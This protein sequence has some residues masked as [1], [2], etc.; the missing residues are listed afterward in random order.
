MIF[1][2]LHKIL[3]SLHKKNYIIEFYS[4]NAFSIALSFYH[5][6]SPYNGLCYISKEAERFS[7]D[8]QYHKHNK[9]VKKQLEN[10][11]KMVYTLYKLNQLDLVKKM[12]DNYKI[13]T[14]AG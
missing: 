6:N 14:L 5:K 3:N 1:N 11:C 13:K 4:D 9:T 7:I 10:V 8:F 12:F 2:K